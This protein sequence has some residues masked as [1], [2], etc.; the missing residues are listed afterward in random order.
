M[1][2]STST[3]TI[4]ADGPSAN[5]RLETDRLIL[6]RVAVADAPA[7]EASCREWE[8]VR[9]TASIPHPYPEGEAA[10]FLASAERKWDEGSFFLLAA[11]SKAD[12]RY[13]GQVGLTPDADA[14]DSA[15]L[16][17]IV[18]RPA[19]GRGL[20]TEMARAGLRFGFDTLGLSHIFARVF[21]ENDASNRLA[22][23][24]GMTFREI[25]WIDAFAREKHVQVNWYD[26]RREDW[27]EAQ[28][29]GVPS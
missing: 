25:G 17:Y 24:L 7:V 12:G 8:S 28:S 26:L 27:A 4:E 23:R 10:R 14:P 19:W 11:Q 21:L 2:I 1:P 13:V 3:P 22:R 20:G 5:P 6:R 18:A 16:S 29:S 15:E 9:Y